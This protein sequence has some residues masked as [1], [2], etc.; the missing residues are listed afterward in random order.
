MSVNQRIALLTLVVA[1]YDDAIA[2]YPQKLNFQLLEDTDLGAG[3]RWVRVAPRG[4]GGGAELLLAR[5]ASPEQAT[6]VGNQTGGRVAL[7]LYTDNL[8][9]DYQQLRAAGVTIVRPPMTQTYR[10]V[11]VFADLYGNLWDL[12]EPPPA[13]SV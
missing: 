7:F 12:L 8:A 5:A 6:R 4:P 3:K 2:F 11:L 1:D 9:R 10:Q 13:H